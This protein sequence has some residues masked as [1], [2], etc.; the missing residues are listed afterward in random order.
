MI[1]AEKHRAVECRDIGGTFHCLFCPTDRQDCMGTV[2]QTHVNIATC[3][4]SIIQLSVALLICNCL[5]CCRSTQTSSCFPEFLF[6]S[7]SASLVVLS[8]FTSPGLN[9]SLANN[10][11]IHS[12]RLLLMR[13]MLLVHATVV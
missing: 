10:E 12:S 8:I 5:I 6:S 9:N 11:K 4:S 7:F 3:V 13:C 2:E 1:S